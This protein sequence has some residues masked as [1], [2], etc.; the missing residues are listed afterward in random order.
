MKQEEDGHE[1]RANV[2]PEKN[3]SDS[4]VA[5]KMNDMFRFCD[6]KNIS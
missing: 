3:I 1:S 6:S 5:R 2:G 4:I